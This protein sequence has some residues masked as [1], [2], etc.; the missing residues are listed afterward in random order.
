MKAHFLN[1]YSTNIAHIV[2]NRCRL[3]ISARTSERFISWTLCWCSAKC[4][5]DKNSNYRNDFYLLFFI[6]Y[7][8][9]SVTAT[10]VRSGF[11][12]ISIRHNKRIRLLNETKRLQGEKESHSFVKHNNETLLC[13]ATQDDRDYTVSNANCPV[14]ITSYDDWSDG[15]NLIE[16]LNKLWRKGIRA[17]GGIR[18]PRSRSVYSV[19][20]RLL[21][22]CSTPYQCSTEHKAVR[23][24]RQTGKALKAP[25][26]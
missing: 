10:K 9:V 17:R 4:Q 1:S 15:K 6:F 5:R 3:F 8:F 12:S 19:R 16:D 25:F 18:N 2:W 11:D 22:G 14:D 23:W 7:F 13:S 26:G 20:Y 21:R 24:W